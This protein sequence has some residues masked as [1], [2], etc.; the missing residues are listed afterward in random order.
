MSTALIV[1]SFG[2]MAYIVY[3][4]GPVNENSRGDRMP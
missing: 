4:G 1:V 2:F 3:H